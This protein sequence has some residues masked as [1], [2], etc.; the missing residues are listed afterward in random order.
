MNEL[1]RSKRVDYEVGHQCFDQLAMTLFLMLTIP[2]HGKKS[3]CYQAEET[4][5]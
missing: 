4:S 5:E 2:A 1:D 3:L